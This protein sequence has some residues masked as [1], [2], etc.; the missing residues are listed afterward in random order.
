VTSGRPR[1]ACPSG[2]VGAARLK[3]KLP[4]DI[5]AE[6]DRKEVQKLGKE[7]KRR[8]RSGKETP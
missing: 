7:E 2:F 8:Q 3:V 5:E 4:G 1:N 6:Y